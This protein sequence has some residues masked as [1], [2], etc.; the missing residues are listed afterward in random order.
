MKINEVCKITGLTKKA[1]LYYQQKKLIDPKTDDNGYRDFSDTDVERLKQISVLRSLGLSIPEISNILDSGFSKEEIRKCITRKELQNDLS[2]E[3]T[4][5][6][7]ELLNGE[8]IEKIQNKIIELDHKK[9]IKERLLE[10]F[11]GFYGRLI[12]IH[13]SRFLND[14]LVTKEQEEAYQIILNFLDEVEPPEMPDEILRQLE[15]AQNFWTDDRISEVE[16]R[17]IEY[18]E[19]PDV[20]FEEFQGIENQY[21]QIKETEAFQS[22]YHELMKIMKSF[23]ETSGYYDIFIPA[24][25][26]LSPTYEAYVQQLLKANDAFLERFPDYQPTNEFNRSDK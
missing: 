3:Q 8:C 12:M 14:P 10:V 24:M 21:N 4:E 7:K 17:K 15:K 11:P 18:I 20:F 22:L 5:L 9:S 13:F 16:E 19:N 26:K 6:L 25:R 23:C 1:V 2:I